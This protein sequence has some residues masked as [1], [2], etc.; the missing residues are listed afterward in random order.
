MLARTLP[1]TVTVIAHWK[2]KKLFTIEKWEVLGSS[3]F[4]D[5]PLLKELILIY[6]TN[7]KPKTLVFPCWYDPI[8]RLSLVC[9][10]LNFFQL[11]ATYK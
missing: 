3:Y 4:Y 8:L 5:M 7:K 2:V 1:L 10:C 6:I 11:K 9:L